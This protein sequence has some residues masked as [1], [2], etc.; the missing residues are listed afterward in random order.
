MSYLDEEQLDDHII[1][2]LLFNYHT[3][4]ADLARVH[5]LVALI[6]IQPF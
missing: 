2:S 6:F 4:N 3:C 1:S 5:F